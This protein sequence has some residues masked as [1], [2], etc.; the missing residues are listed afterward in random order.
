LKTTQEQLAKEKNTVKKLQEQ[1]EKTVSL[2]TLDR[3]GLAHAGGEPCA[4]AGWA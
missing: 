1:L 4:P 2:C 3:L